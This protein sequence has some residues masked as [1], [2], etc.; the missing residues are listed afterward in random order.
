MTLS[1]NPA[2]RLTIFVNENDQWHHRPLHTEIVH[3]A[4]QAGLAGAS[5]FHGVEGFGRSQTVHT[6]R[7]L[8]LTDDLPCSI[9]IVDSEEKVRA[10]LPQIEELVAEALVVLDR[11]EV[12]RHADGPEPRP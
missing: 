7:I 1:A 8:S 5:V 2:T 3:R 4:H 10:L 11:V 9:V 6:A 12:L